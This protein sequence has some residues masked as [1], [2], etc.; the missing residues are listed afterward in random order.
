MVLTQTRSI[1]RHL[2]RRYGLA[3][4]TSAAAAAAD[5]AVEAMFDWWNGLFDVTYCDY[6]P[7]AEARCHQPQHG[8]VHQCV[9]LTP[10]FTARRQKYLESTLPAHLQR[11]QAVLKEHGGPWLI[12]ASLCYADFVLF[13][14]L[15]QHL[16]LSTACLKELPQLQQY[17]ARFAKLPAIAAYRA[18]DRFRAEPLHNRYSHFHTGWVGPEWGSG[19]SG[20]SEVDIEPESA[21]VVSSS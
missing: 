20:G 11:V 6:P 19:S 17:H 7:S 18:S 1:L 4:D 3:C 12:G 5:Q 16:A 14:L 21:A 10:K 13:E 8:A 9:R 15:D 2:A